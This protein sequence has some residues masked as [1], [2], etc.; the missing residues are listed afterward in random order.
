[1]GSGATLEAPAAEVPGS[2]VPEWYEADGKPVPGDPPPVR[3]Q[4]HRQGG[5]YYYHFPS[6]G[7]R[8]AGELDASGSGN[9]GT[10]P[11]VLTVSRETVSSGSPVELGGGQQQGGYVGGQQQQQGG[12]DGGQQQQQGGY[13]GGQQ[14]QQQ[15]GNQQ[16]QQGSYYY[17]G[18]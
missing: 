16:H 17:P 7:Q 14:H 12:Y 4:I 6:P 1:M 8:L 3:P 18:S 13:D 15:Q 11:L 9:G 2:Q 5:S 10:S